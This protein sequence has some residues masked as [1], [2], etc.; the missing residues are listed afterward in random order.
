MLDQYNSLLFAGASLLILLSL[1]L[2]KY[3]MQK[4]MIS[5]EGGRKLLHFM[6]VITCGW[7]VFY[8]SERELLAIIF[9]ICSFVLFFIAH[10]NWLLPNERESYGIALFPL[11]FGL[12]L[13]TPVSITAVV[14]AIWVLGICDPLAGY[15]GQHYADKKYIF[16]YEEKSWLGFFVFYIAAMTISCFFLGWTAAVLVLALVP[17]LSELFSYKGSDN[18][19]IPLIASA[20]YTVV[21]ENPIFPFQWLIFLVV[22]AVL[23]IT[24]RKKW[25]TD[26]GTA[27]ALLLGTVIVFSSDPLLIVS[28][29]IFFVAGSLTSRLHP[30][31]KDAGGRDAIQVFS[32][33]LVAVLCLLVFMLT[34]NS[35][36]ICAYFMSI[37][38]SFADTMSSDIGLYFRQKTY[39]IL[40]FQPIAAGLSGG[41]SVAGTLAGVVTSVLFSGMMFFIFDLEIKDA[42]FI[43]LA[44]TFGMILDSIIGSKWQLKH[45][46][47]GIVTEDTGNTLTQYY[48]GVPWMSNNMV[49]MLTNMIVT[50][51]SVVIL[52]LYTASH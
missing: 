39:D 9:L 27:A 26:S 23:G 15:V 12:L 45:I 11:A 6:A 28:I 35:I 30:E 51:T 2:I 18:L 52:G 19:S 14:F 50:G 44:G 40:T 22:L 3:S 46:H 5:T 33:G 29:G 48:K 41:I 43:A 31:L 47:K 13:L 37:C 7:V 16:L 24:Y 42:C 8:T 20:W 32:N 21:I 1:L 25:L 10:K 38:I 17:A 34:K 49:N 4:A 36:Y